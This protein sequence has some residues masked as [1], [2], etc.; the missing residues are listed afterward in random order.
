[1]IY[2]ATGKYILLNI[3]IALKILLFLCVEYHAA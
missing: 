3:L 1:M 2:T